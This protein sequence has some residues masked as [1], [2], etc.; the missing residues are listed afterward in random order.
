M[1][2]FPSVGVERQTTAEVVF[3]RCEVVLVMARELVTPIEDRPDGTRLRVEEEV[4]ESVVVVEQYRVGCVGDDFEILVEA[5]AQFVGQ[6]GESPRLLDTR[7]V[8]LGVGAKPCG[9]IGFEVRNR[10]VVDGRFAVGVHA[11]TEPSVP[12][13]R[14]GRVEFA[15]V[16]SGVAGGAGERIVGQ[17][18]GAR[19]RLARCAFHQE[20]RCGHVVVVVHV[21]ENVGDRDFGPATHEVEDPRFGP[22]RRAGPRTNRISTRSSGPR[23]ASRR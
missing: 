17:R 20:E 14:G 2:D 11:R 1:D 15:E 7:E 23:P 10:E 6:L 22:K 3:G 13:E 21:A 12:V 9:P 19:N 5:S 18:L 4:S 8:L 16:A